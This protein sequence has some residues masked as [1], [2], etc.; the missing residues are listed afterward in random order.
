MVT[1]RVRIGS[2]K[3][4]DAEVVKWLKQAYEAAGAG[5]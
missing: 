2:P 3:E 4:L 1:H 5:K